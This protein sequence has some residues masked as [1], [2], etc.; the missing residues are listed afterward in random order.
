MFAS[1]DD[2]AGLFRPLSPEEARRAEALIPV[3]ED[4]LR[5]EA[6]N[7]GRD[8]DLSVSSGALLSS[9][10]KSV[11]VDVVS[12]TLMTS[13]TGGD[14]VSQFTQSALGYSVS[15]T[16]LNPGGGLFI[17]NSELKRLGL[18]RQVYGGIELYAD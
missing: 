8:L 14:P 3:V 16:Y 15:G 7:R 6:K 12:R 5:Q 10:L 9:V 17:K 1:V 11:I 13:T 2:V 18:N 4:S